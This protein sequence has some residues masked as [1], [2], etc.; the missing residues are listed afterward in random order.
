[1]E[2]MVQELEFEAKTQRQLTETIAETWH[3][4]L[5]LVIVVAWFFLGN[6][7]VQHLRQNPNFNHIA[8]YLRMILLEGAV[9]AFIAWG[10]HRRGGSLRALI[11]GRWDSAKHVFVDIGVAA[12]FWI[13]SVVALAIFRV[14]LS[15]LD[16]S[17]AAGVA[18]A[19]QSS[20]GTRGVELA[21]SLG[22]LAPRTRTEI[23]VWIILCLAVGFCEEIIFRGYLQRQF[24]AWTNLP[25][26]M[27]L[28]AVLFGL[29]HGYQGRTSQIVLGAYGLLFG[30][31]AENRKSLR[32]GMMAHA[33]HDTVSGLVL[34][35]LR[36]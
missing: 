21:R 7:R 19:A 24:A 5:L 2:L 22:F 15:G 23:L 29:G 20:H 14:A 25:L 6:L 16:P 9:V 32:P 34:S 35:I 8:M 4:L 18:K 31:L 26:G 28:S 11:R 3:T 1:M 30:I 33:W 36:R 10:V 12:M 17:P 13:V 27:I